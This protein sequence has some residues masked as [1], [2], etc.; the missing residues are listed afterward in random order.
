MESW[1]LILLGLVCLFL[2]GEG[3]VRGSAAIAVRLGLPPLIAGLTV[4]AFGT[5]SPELVVSLKAALDG[6]GSIAVGNVVGSNI[7]NVGLILGITAL[8]CPLKAQLQILRF[9]TPVMILATLVGAALLWDGSL[10]RVEGAC[11]FAAL[12]CY[13][14]ATVWMAKRTDVSTEVT[15]EFAESV[16]MPA[17]PVWKDVVFIVA[18]LGLLVLGSQL[19]VE[20]AVTVAKNLGW[21][22]AMIGLTIVAGGT[23]TPELA[24]SL[25]AAL[26]KQPDIALGNI[27][28][29]NVFNILGIL[30]IS[31][32]ITPLVAQ[33]ITHF[34]L[35]AMVV[36][37]AV[38]L[39]II[40]TGRRFERWEGAAL[41]VGYGFYLW[42][43][44]PSS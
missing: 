26:R 13:V 4:V 8:I 17:G 36:F 29:S 41:L 20:G 12:V 30:G 9:D 35:G 6:L 22:D 3:L 38:L 1:I 2:G 21:S 25:V 43:L 34:D 7:F 23:S 32:L 27:I 39:P 15:A 33:G 37:S 44:W 40:W 19:L 18:G 5:S 14:A 10:G 31:A 24:A 28:G 42:K 11:F 16:P